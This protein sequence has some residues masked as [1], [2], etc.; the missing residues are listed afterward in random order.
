VETILLTESDLLIDDICDMLFNNVLLEK[1][2]K[3]IEGYVNNDEP[4]GTVKRNLWI[5]DT[6]RKHVDVGYELVKS[7]YD[8]IPETKN[9]II[10]GFALWFSDRFNKEI[11]SYTCLISEEDLHLTKSEYYKTLT[12]FISGVTWVE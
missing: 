7:I 4:L 10:R 3:S 2:F 8:Y 1:K 12:Q 6:K 9:N 11:N 5:Y